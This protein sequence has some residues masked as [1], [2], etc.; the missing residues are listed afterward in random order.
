MVHTRTMNCYLEKKANVSLA[1]HPVL[2]FAVAF[3]GFPICLLLA[4]LVCTAIVTLPFAW[5]FGW[6]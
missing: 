2:A 4:V 6:I 1:N 5:A 3:I